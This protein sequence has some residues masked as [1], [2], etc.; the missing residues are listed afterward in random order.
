MLEIGTIVQSTAGRD[1]NYLLC[2]VGYEDGLVLIADGKERTLERPKKKNP[3]HLAPLLQ[4]QPFT[5]ELRGNKALKKALNRMALKAL[6]AT[7]R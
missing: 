6:G 5:W 7:E 2:V 3:N 1:K 4:L